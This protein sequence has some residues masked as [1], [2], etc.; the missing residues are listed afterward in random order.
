M[1]PTASI[2]ESPVSTT[3]PPFVVGR[4]RVRKRSGRADRVEDEVGAASG[5]SAA[6][7]ASTAL[8]RRSS[9]SVAPKVRASA[10]GAACRSMAMICAA[11]AKHRTLNHIQADAAGANDGDARAARA[12]AR[13]SSRRRRRSPP[14]SQAWRAHRRGRLRSTTTARFFGDDGEVGEA[15]RAEEVTQVL[16]AGVQPLAPDGSR[17]RYVV[18]SRRSQRTARPSH[19][20][21]AD[22]A[23]RRPAEHDVIARLD[24]RDVRPDLAHD[25]RAFMAEHDRRAHRPI[26]ARGMKI[27]V[28][29]AG[30][31]DLDEDFAR[32]GRIEL[33][34][35]RP[36]AAARVPR[37]WRL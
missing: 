22:A 35:L 9:I 24:A 34:V 6:R 17:F 26:V 13:R 18:L 5:W 8:A 20:G 7:T 16:S 37:E 14:R 19:T 29:D 31:L 3:V 36:T 32:A 12:L 10:S 27:A 11:P 25:A 4:Q 28:A 33:G 15:G 23:R 1:L 2:R 30:R 21:R